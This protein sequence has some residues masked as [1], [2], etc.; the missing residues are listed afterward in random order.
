MWAC[1]VLQQPLSRELRVLFAKCAG[2]VLG[3]DT[4]AVVQFMHAYNYYEMSGQ[5]L[6]LNAQVLERCSQR[7][8]SVVALSKPSHSQTQIHQTLTAM[9]LNA[10]L[11]NSSDN[12]MLRIDVEVQLDDQRKVAVEADGPWHFFLNQ[13]HR[14]TGSTV[15]RDNTLRSLGYEVVSVPFAE[16]A[17]LR[18]PDAQKQYLQSLLKL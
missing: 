1:A 3:G 11:E 10:R 5:Q 18:T 7:A 9:G 16:W 8:R 17:R 15:L 4:R 13:P 2:G 6:Q 12:G 14:R